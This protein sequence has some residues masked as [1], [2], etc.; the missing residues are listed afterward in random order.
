[1]ISYF[2][3]LLLGKVHNFVNLHMRRSFF[4]RE[5]SRQ[6]KTDCLSMQMCNF[7]A[8]KYYLFWIMC[9]WGQLERMTVKVMCVPRTLNRY[10]RWAVLS[11]VYCVCVRHSPLSVKIMFLSP[12]P[13]SPSCWRQLCVRPHSCLFAPKLC[14]YRGEGGG[15]YLLRFCCR[16]SGSGRSCVAARERGEGV[17]LLYQRHSCVC[18][19]APKYAEGSTTYLNKTR[20]AL[21]SRNW[22]PRVEG[23]RGDEYFRWFSG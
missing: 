11:L 19:L 23:C 17:R 8:V 18:V 5:F 13:L 14:V 3:N 9:L 20:I 2:C 12:L 10:V 6:K 7:W 4:H 16:K 21:N 1:M 15:R 22:W